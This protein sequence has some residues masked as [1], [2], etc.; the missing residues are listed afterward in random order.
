MR[1]KTCET[2][3]SVIRHLKTGKAPKEVAATLGVTWGCVQQV[4]IRHREA[5]CVYIETYGLR[6]PQCSKPPPKI[7]QPLINIDKSHQL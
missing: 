3:Q 7:L 6:H 1:E 4:I 5:R 2:I